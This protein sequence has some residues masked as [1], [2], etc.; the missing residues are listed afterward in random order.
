MVI[1]DLLP[2][3]YEPVKSDGVETLLQIQVKMNRCQSR[4]GLHNGFDRKKLHD[5]SIGHQTYFD[6]YKQLKLYVVVQQF[7]SLL[8]GTPCAHGQGRRTM[9]NIATDTEMETIPVIHI[10][11]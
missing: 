6:H 4:G 11:E 7:Q 3:Y 9:Q 10:C 2:K 8:P 1:G 5:H